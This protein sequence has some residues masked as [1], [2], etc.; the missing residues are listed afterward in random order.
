MN[1]Q[2]VAAHAAQHAREMAL[3]LI[4]FAVKSRSYNAFGTR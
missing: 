3:H 2:Q 1:V 4:G